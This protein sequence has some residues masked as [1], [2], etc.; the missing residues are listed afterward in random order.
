MEEGKCSKHFFL[1]FFILSHKSINCAHSSA[2][3]GKKA[4][5][6]VDTTM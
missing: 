2:E 1:P 6:G 5:G 3:I 4:S